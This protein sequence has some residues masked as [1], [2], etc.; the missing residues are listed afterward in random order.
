MNK[1][2]LHLG[3]KIVG[4]LENTNQLICPNC[5]KQGIDYLYVGD[6]QTRV[7][8]VQIWCNKCL[9]GIYIS[10]AIAPQKANFVNFDTEIKDI[11]P[12]YEFVEQ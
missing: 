4:D 12:K 11:V 1:K 6:E 10:R 2:W 5:G 9:K 8:Y 7:G 3:S